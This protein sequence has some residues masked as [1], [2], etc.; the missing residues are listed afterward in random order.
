M[1]CVCVLGSTGPT[2]VHEVPTAPTNAGLEG[3]EVGVNDILLGHDGVK[4]GP[5]NT[6]P[7]ICRTTGV[8]VSLQIQCVCAGREGT[9]GSHCGHDTAGYTQLGHV[10]R[11]YA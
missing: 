8:R 11:S 2:T 7:L 1:V 9:A 3:R 10:P 4:V 6:L 5:D